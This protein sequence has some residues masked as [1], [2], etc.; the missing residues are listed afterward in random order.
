MAI[1][2]L[3]ILEKDTGIR[4]ALFIDWDRDQGRTF[5]VQNWQPNWQQVSHQALEFDGIDGVEALCLVW[6][7][8]QRA[9]EIEVTGSDQI[10]MRS[11]FGVEQLWQLAGVA[12][13]EAEYDDRKYAE[14]CESEDGAAV[15]AL[16]SAVPY[17]EY[18]AEA[19]ADLQR[20]F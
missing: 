15:Y 20:E 16:E 2:F 7:D 6:R 14:Y 8:R 1:Q 11:L 4:R 19:Q 13:T 10:T 9:G 12:E 3:T 17:S 5:K 18:D